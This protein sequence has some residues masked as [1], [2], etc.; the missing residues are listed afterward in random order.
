MLSIK[1][2]KKRCPLKNNKILYIASIVLVFSILPMGCSNL[3]QQNKHQIDVGIEEEPAPASNQ[4]TQTLSPLLRSIKTQEDT[5]IAIGVFADYAISRLD[6]NE[7]LKTQALSIHPNQQRDYVTNKEWILKLKALDQNVLAFMEF[8]ARKDARLENPNKPLSNY[9]VSLE[10]LANIIKQ[11]SNNKLKVSAKELAEIQKELRKSMPNLTTEPSSTKLFPLEAYLVTW[12][13]ITGDNGSAPTGSIKTNSIIHKVHNNKIKPKFCGIEAVI[14]TGIVI[15]IDLIFNDGN[16]VK[17]VS[18]V[19]LDALG[20][21]DSYAPENSSTRINY[22]N[23]HNLFSALR[24]ISPY[25]EFDNSNPPS[26]VAVF[27]PSKP[28]E[29]NYISVA[30]FPTTTYPA[31]STEEFEGHQQVIANSAMQTDG[32]QSFGSQWWENNKSKFIIGDICFFRRTNSIGKMMALISSWTHTALI[33]NP[34]MD[35]CIESL[36]YNNYGVRITNPSTDWAP[37]ISFSSKR[38]KPTS[39]SREKI[40]SA[41]SRS[42]SL[43]LGTQYFPSMPNNNTAPEWADFVYAW[44]DKSTDTMYCSSFVWNTFKLEGLDLDSKRLIIREPIDN[45]SYKLSTDIVNSIICA[46][47]V[48]GFE[49]IGVSPDEIYYSEHLQSDMLDVSFGLENINKPMLS[50]QTYTYNTLNTSLPLIIADTVIDNT[51]TQRGSKIESV[52]KVIVTNTG[53]LILNTTE[54][55]ELNSDFE[56]EYGG[57]LDISFD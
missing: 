21:P 30:S 19:I 54:Y 13:Y 38:I 57:E 33:L 1:K 44:A 7:Q 56:V 6:V 42:R 41:V 18:E 25:V 34:E 53:Q 5:K 28:A 55:V 32:G 9:L 12:A 15:A 4:L 46:L 45:F 47:T 50:M 40:E 51:K 37:A 27:L 16:F 48:N 10:R 52:G 23:S 22:F 20:I 31:T 29:D 17:Y 26:E 14:G 24:E 39:L 35:L 49:F 36:P 3:L 2:E 11:E 8:Q 43:Y